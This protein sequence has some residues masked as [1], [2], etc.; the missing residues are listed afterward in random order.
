MLEAEAAR[1]CQILLGRESAS[2]LLNLGASTREYREVDRPH[3][4][5][6]LFAPLR[7]AGFAIVHFDRKAAEGVDLVGDVTDAAK[8]EDLKA[9]GFRC[10]LMASLLEH[11]RDPASVAAIAEDIVGPGGL[12]LATVPCSYPY[13]A[14]PIDIG[15][16][17]SPEKLAKLFGRSR[18]IATE[19][20]TGPTYREDLEAR[21]SSVGRELG[22]MLL[23]LPTIA[24]R[25]RSV[26]SRLHRWRWLDRPYRVAIALVEVGSG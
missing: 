8:V 7:R 11:L 23:A 3:I 4:D 13:H 18:P 6:G 2:P 20:V 16:R 12:I 22:R 25:L 17:P 15:F 24:V 19:T 26:A 5:R 14:D 9:R 10:V 21:G 1:L